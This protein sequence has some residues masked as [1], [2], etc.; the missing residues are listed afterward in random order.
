MNGY[1][2][3]QVAEQ[4]GFTSSTL[5]YYEDEGILCPERTASGYRSYDDDDVVTLHFIARAK[6]FGLTLDEIADLVSLLDDHRCAPV[7][8]RLRDLVDVKITEAQIRLVEL[9]GFT[10]QLQHVAAGLRGAPTPDGPCDSGCGCTIDRLDANEISGGVGESVG[11]AIG[12]RDEPPIVCTLTPDDVG[13]R[14]ADWSMLLATATSREETSGG[15]RVH[16]DRGTDIVSLATLA[17]AESSCCQWAT[18]AITVV[19]DEVLLDVTGPP[20][21]REAIVATLGTSAQRVIR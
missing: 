11:V 7:Q 19:P 5:R 6:S 16:F 15:V 9:T 18:I 2:I 4:T 20:A 21:G 17:A 3:S 14:I 8:D 13:S 12:R 1:S 10:A